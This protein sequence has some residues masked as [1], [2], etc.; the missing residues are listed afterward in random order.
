MTPEI[1]GR[2]TRTVLGTQAD[3]AASTQATQKGK[4]FS[5]IE[6]KI[7]D[8]K[9]AD[10]VEERE[11]RLDAV[12][13]E[14]EAIAAESGITREEVATLASRALVD[15]GGSDARYQQQVANVLLGLAARLPSNPR[16]IKRVINAFSIYETVGRLY[17]NYRTMRGNRD[18][19]RRWRQLA[20]WTTLATEWPE[21]WRELARDPRLRGGGL[22]RRGGDPNQAS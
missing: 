17:F 19:S 16:Q 4:A 5:E 6:R 12:Q 2:F 14:T 15:S 1:R 8:A 9:R 3:L 20:L 21:T 18:Q 11:K 22:W 7:D 10:T 13:R